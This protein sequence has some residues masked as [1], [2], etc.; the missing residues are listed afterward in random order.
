MTKESLLKIIQWKL[1]HDVEYYKQSLPMLLNFNLIQLIGWAIDND[2]I[3]A[4][5]LYQ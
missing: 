3:D 2:I 4:G 5:N 1:R